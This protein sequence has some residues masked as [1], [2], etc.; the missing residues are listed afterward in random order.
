MNT[1]ELVI[2]D[3][4]GVLFNS[5]EANKRYYSA[6]LEMVGRAPLRSD[7]LASVHMLTTDQAIHLLFRD[8]PVR[9]A[10][11]FQVASRLNYADFI[12]F[13][14]FEPGVPETLNA[15]KHHIRMAILTNRTTT[16]PRLRDVFGLDRWFDTIVCAMDVERPK[17]DPEGMHLILSTLSVPSEKAVYVGDSKIDEEVAAR[18]GIP[19]IAYKNREL[20]QAAFHVERFPDLLG[21]LLDHGPVIRSAPPT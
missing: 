4:D 3:C 10:Q 8:D 20:R 6:I 12:P 1:I 18:A 21:I 5:L 11:A 14:D 17:P 16:M 2:F 7:E 15:I 9:K 19:F 13:M